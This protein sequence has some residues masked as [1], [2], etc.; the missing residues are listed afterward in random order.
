VFLGVLQADIFGISEGILETTGTGNL[1]ARQLV[2]IIM[3]V[4]KISFSAKLH[5]KILGNMPVSRE[6]FSK[7][8]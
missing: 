8:W 1:Y 2:T 3:T 6:K 7:Y 4:L 5:I